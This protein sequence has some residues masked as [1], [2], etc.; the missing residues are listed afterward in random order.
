MQD[1]ACCFRIIFENLRYSAA[2]KGG[3]QNP[4][5][6]KSNSVLGIQVLGIVL[7]N[8]LPPVGGADIEPKE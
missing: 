2:T 4:V 5:Y 3:A 8:G 6:M 7:A 1:G